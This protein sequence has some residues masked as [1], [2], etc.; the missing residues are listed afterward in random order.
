MIDMANQSLQASAKT[1][2]IYFSDRWIFFFT[3]LVCN[4]KQYSADA[5][6]KTGFRDF[7]KSHKTNFP[8]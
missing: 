6:E 4:F 8:S 7:F 1:K 5:S 2:I 3:I